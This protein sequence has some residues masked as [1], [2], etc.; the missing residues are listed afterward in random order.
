MAIAITVTPSTGTAAKTFHHVEVSGLDDTDF[1]TYDSTPDADSTEPYRAEVTFKYYFQFSE[2]GLI[3]GRSHV[4][5]PDSS[6]GKGVWDSVMFPDAGTYT[7]SVHNAGTGA[8][9][10]SVGVTVS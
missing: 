1:S 2:G 10:K 5:T 6:T 3:K 9:L 7:V 8:T 4:F